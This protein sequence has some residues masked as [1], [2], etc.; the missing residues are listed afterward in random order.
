MTYSEAT[1]WW[2]LYSNQILS[3][4]LRKKDEIAMRVL[5]IKRV[6]DASEI[7]FG[8]TS[9]IERKFTDSVNKLKKHYELKGVK[10]ESGISS[11]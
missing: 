11:N 6:L 4:A 8:N 5:Q 1:V 7:L 10:G 3:D 2:L 9:E